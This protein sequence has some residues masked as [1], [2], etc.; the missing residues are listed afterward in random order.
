[1]TAPDVSLD[2]SQMTNQVT[3]PDGNTDDSPQLAK[4]ADW[5]FHLGSHL[6]EWV[7]SGVVLWGEV[8]G[9]VILVAT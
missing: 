2:D 9:V 8:I 1:M 6:W 4:T 5:R 7:S 3:T